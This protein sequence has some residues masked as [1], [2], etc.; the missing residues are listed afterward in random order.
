[1]ER[2]ATLVEAQ[3]IMGDNFIGIEDL[4]LIC[5]KFPIILPPIYPDINFSKDELTQK[6]DD[7]ILLIGLDEFKNSLPMTLNNLR[8]AFGVD[9]DLAEPCF[10]NQDWYLKEDFMSMKLETKWYL[11]RKKIIDSSRAI[12]PT[13]LEEKH[14]FPSAV[15]CAYAFFVVWFTKNKVLWKN[16]FVWCN[17]FDNSDD[18]IY[19]GRYYDENGLSKNGFSIHRH[20]S[21][22]NNYGVI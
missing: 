12:Q 9:P 15:M 19:V 6:K 1:M 17:D 21:I 2:N 3:Q 10:Y 8:S 5:D 18:R 11:I 13:I 16:D 20:L 4:K 7:Y 22:R 14:I